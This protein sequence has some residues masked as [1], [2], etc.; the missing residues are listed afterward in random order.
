MTGW[1]LTCNPSV[2]D[3]ESYRRDGHTL[4]SWS[5]HRYRQQLT[6]GDPFALW[7]TG[8]DGGLVAHGR[9][10]GAPWFGPPNHGGYW[11]EDPGERWYVPLAVDEW[12]ERVVPRRLIAEDLRVAKATIFTQPFAGNPHRLADSQWE[13]VS[14][15]MGHTSG[16]DPDPELKPGDGMHRAELQG[17]YSGDGKGDISST[18]EPDQV[19]VGTNYR[20]A[21]EDVTP[22]ASE[23]PE[24]S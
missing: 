10:T 21:D 6:A 8:A 22:A 17:R 4:D 14:E 24:W 11:R 5:V 3:L 19:S 15:L 9:I 13:A 18:T 12:L 1:I 16:E 7:V 2:F 20:P 23:T